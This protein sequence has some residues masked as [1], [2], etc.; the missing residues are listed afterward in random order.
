MTY[1]SQCSVRTHGHGEMHDLSGELA[2]VL[3][4][5]GMNS[6]IVTAFVIGST[7]GLT[8]IEF[9]PGLVEDMRQAMER[10]APE[11][12]QYAHE[13]RWHD[14]NGHAHVR[15]SIIGPSVTIPFAEGQSALGT[16]QQLVL[17]DFDT[18]ERDRTVV[19]QVLGE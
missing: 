12:G 9:E 8:T 6:G 14:D 3:A 19:F 18:R 7:A 16:W 5:S 1:S 17:V 13:A 4:R 10:V 15:A 11:G 2:T